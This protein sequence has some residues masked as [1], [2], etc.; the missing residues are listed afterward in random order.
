MFPLVERDV[1]QLWVA[2]AISS[3]DVTRHLLRPIFFTSG[4]RWKS[5]SISKHHINHPLSSSS[6][7]CWSSDISGPGARLQNQLFKIVYTVSKLTPKKRKHMQTTDS[8]NRK[9][10]CKFPIFCP[11]RENWKLCQP[12]VSSINMYLVGGFSPLKHMKVSWDD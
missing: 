10:K 8:R 11:G 1:S 4:D 7:R 9:P 12:Q 2:P 3:T 6:K 5:C